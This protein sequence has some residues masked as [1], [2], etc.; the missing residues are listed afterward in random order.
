MQIKELEEHFFSCRKHFSTWALQEVYTVWFEMRKPRKG[1]KESD[2]YHFR[3]DHTDEHEKQFFKVLMGDFRERLA[4]PDKFALHFRGR[5][6]TSIKLE[7]RSG[8]TFDVQVA[9]N[10][11]RLVLQSGWKSFVSAHDLQMGDFL[12][13]KYDG[14]SQLKVVIFDISGC[15]KVLTYPIPKDAAPGWKMGENTDILSICHDPPMKSLQ[16][17]KKTLNQKGSS[18][19][20]DRRVQSAPSYIL[21][22]R[23]HLT[24]T[25]TKKLK[26]KVRAIHSAIPIYACVLRKSNISTRSSELIIPKAYADV[27]LPFVEQTLILQC[28]GKSW[29]V[30]CRIRD[31]NRRCKR[32]LKGWKGF[33]RDNKLQL[34][35]LCLFELL[36]NK[37]YT[38]NVHIIRAK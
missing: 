26:E 5:I 9:K 17:D 2:A 16:S 28:N 29:E 12:V 15:E 18:R 3:N 35:D 25:Q 8:Y 30:R 20:S 22:C 10:L 24:G 1:C 4:I 23:T 14:I 34:G 36:K 27:Y 19:L 21:Q 38:M 11:G 6:S 31:S 37:K 33:A 7:S 13:F 32:L